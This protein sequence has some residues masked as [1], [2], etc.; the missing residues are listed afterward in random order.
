MS[1]EILILLV[2]DD[3]L[4]QR[5]SKRILS[6][7]GQVTIAPTFQEAVTLLR[8][9][10]FDIA[11]FDLNLHGELDGLE[12]IKMAKIIGLYSIVL[13]GEP[14]EQILEMALRNGAQD[15]LSKP[16]SD[17]KLDQ[18]LKRFFNNRKHIEFERII[19]KNFITK[20]ANQI[21]ELYKIKNLP[22]SDKPVF[23]HGNTGT[24]KRV[25]A[26][27]ITEILG[28][29]KFLELN[30]SQYSDELIASELFG[31]VKG[32]FTGATSDKEGLLLQANGGVILLDEIHA[33]SLK[34][35]KTLLK[36]LE[37][38]RFYPVG[39]VKPVESDFRLLSSTCEEIHQLIKDGKFREDLFARISTFQIRLLPL[40]ERKEDIQLLLEHFIS[41]HLVQIFI[42]DDAKNLLN[43]YVW[44]RNTREIE[45]LVVNWIVE[46]KRLIEVETLP[47]HIKNNSPAMNKFIPD[48]YLDMVEE[49]GLND[50]M[51]YLKKEIVTEVIKRNDNSIR[52]AASTMGS[53]Y[54]NLAAFLRQNKEIDLNRRAIT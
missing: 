10:S 24:G 7:Y 33:L 53:S 20:S 39:A 42:T 14:R 8:S 9:K 1:D 11:F 22:I 34:A 6:R 28:Q 52:K 49:Y 3:L 12:L 50:F 48:L 27:S 32:A 18:V 47:L 29:T 26:H 41:K 38:K 5:T 40:K 35:Q 13:S 21:E 30:C 54:S 17:G 2:E 31:H 15:F 43:N 23:I 19:N 45:D 25:V 36:A 51:T 37:E 46:G 16:F 44:P 4:T